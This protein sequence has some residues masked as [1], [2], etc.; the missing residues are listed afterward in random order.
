MQLNPQAVE[1]PAASAAITTLEP[2][3]ADDAPAAAP[4]RAG[5]GLVV[6]GA[7]ITWLYFE[8]TPATYVLQVHKGAIGHVEKTA[9]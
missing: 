7:L 4:V 3:H 5:G 6:A 9:D 1:K 2:I 8:T